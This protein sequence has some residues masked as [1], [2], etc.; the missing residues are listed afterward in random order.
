MEENKMSEIYLNPKENLTACRSIIATLREYKAKNWAIGITYSG[1]HQPDS[2]Y[3]FF[4]QRGLSFESYLAS[5]DLSTGQPT[6][7]ETNIKTL[8]QYAQSIYN[9]EVKSINER[10]NSIKDWQK[11]GWAIG[12]SY[13]R[14]QP[15]GFAK[16]L[17]LRD[18]P[19]SYYVVGGACTYGNPGAYNDII[20]TLN[21][22]KNSL[23]NPS[24]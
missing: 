20:N 22:Y 18:L 10:V 14:C 3:V 24:V 1:T 5:P 19:S 4:E 6:A 13:S 11:K 16:F 17:A 7:Y 15:D 12:L 9:S 8:T 2:F 21:D 23:W